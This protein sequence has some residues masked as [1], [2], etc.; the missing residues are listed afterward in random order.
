MAKNRNRRRGGR[1]QLPHR[2][3]GVGGTRTARDGTEPAKSAG[4]EAGSDVPAAIPDRP[5]GVR[6]KQRRFGHN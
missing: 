3:E 2:L 4:T 6:N 5:A 1:Q